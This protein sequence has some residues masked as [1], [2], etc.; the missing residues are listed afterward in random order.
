M[1]NIFNKSFSPQVLDILKATVCPVFNTILNYNYSNHLKKTQ[2]LDFSLDYHI[3]NTS[4]TVKTC[5]EGM[6]YKYRA[7][8]GYYKLK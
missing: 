8:K 2:S 7:K 3:C 4:H 5:T 1:E 6:D